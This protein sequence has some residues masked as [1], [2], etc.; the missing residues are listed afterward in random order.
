M[1]AGEPVRSKLREST[2]DDKVLTDFAV[3]S[4]PANMIVLPAVSMA[5]LL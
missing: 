4:C 1:L 3:V 5:T 2:A